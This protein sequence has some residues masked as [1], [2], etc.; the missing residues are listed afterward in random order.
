MLLKKIIAKPS[1]IPAF[2]K[3]GNRARIYVHLKSNITNGQVLDKK[4]N[5]LD[6][7]NLFRKVDDKTPY[8][9]AYDRNGSK[10]VGVYGKVEPDSSI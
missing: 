9:E 2:D 4:E 1:P 5:K 10:L 7:S 8:I 3:K 6:E